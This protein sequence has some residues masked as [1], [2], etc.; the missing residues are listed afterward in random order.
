MEDKVRKLENIIEIDLNK[1]KFY[2]TLAFIVSGV[3][4]LALAWHNYRSVQDVWDITISVI[5]F[6]L[7]VLFWMVIVKGLRSWY[8][9]L[10]SSHQELLETNK[11]LDQEV[12]ERIKIEEALKKALKVKNE[13]TSTVSHELRT[14]LAI[15]KE[16]LSLVLRGK[17][18]QL[19]SKTE[20]IVKMASTN[21]DRLGIL[22]NDILDV[23]KIEAGKM[24]VLTETIDIIPVIKECF[25][26]WKLKAD[27]KKIDLS[28]M[29]PPSGVLVFDVDRI[30]FNQIL[31][32]LLSNAIKFTPENGK[33]ELRVEEIEDDVQFSVK[34]TGVGI[35]SKDISKV[36][37]KFQQIRRPMGPGTK[38]TGLGLSIVKSLV[39][40]HGGEVN[41]NSEIGKGSEFKI[42]LPKENKAKKSLDH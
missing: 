30:R 41:V 39:E 7:L 13:L 8:S 32:N 23:S 29:I 21:L 1:P 10:I 37:N 14:P 33:V 11:R 4:Y 18:G 20:E 17:V 16:A 34:D 31:T 6:I 12:L 26:G 3:V 22:I 2:L 5:A 15:S 38:G 36:F 27:T 24:G 40:L 25:N 42:K 28:L 35:A 9:V 19:D